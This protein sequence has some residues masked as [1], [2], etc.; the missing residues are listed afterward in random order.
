MPPH[1]FCMTIQPN[2]HV[3]SERHHAITMHSYKQ[4]NR[5]LRITAQPA[6][7]K[8]IQPQYN[9]TT[10]FMIRSMTHNHV[11][12]QP[13]IVIWLQSGVTMFT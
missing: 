9:L 2:S 5:A 1:T 6:F 11:T 8:A 4:A 12:I 13:C 3:S 7:H 10:Q